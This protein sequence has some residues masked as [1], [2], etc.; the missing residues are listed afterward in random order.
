MIKLNKLITE[1]IS[2]VKILVSYD[3][4]NKLFKIKDKETSEIIKEGDE[5]SVEAFL[6][7][8]GARMDTP[9]FMANYPVTKVNSNAADMSHFSPFSLLE[10][11]RLRHDGT[12]LELVMYPREYQEGCKF[13]PGIKIP[14]GECLIKDIKESSMINLMV[15]QKE[16][17]KDIK[18]IA[19]RTYKEND[20][21]EIA[22][23]T[24]D[25]KYYPFVI[26]PKE[27]DSFANSLILIL[28]GNEISLN[29]EDLKK[30]CNQQDALTV[31]S[32][33]PK[34]C[35]SEDTITEGMAIDKLINSHVVVFESTDLN[36][37][38]RTMF[39]VHPEATY[40]NWK[41][42]EIKENADTNKFYF[43]VQGNNTDALL[44]DDFVLGRLLSENVYITHRTPLHESSPLDKA[45]FALRNG[46][47]LK[48][49]VDSLIK[50][51]LN[52]NKAEKTIKECG[53][54]DVGV[55]TATLAA[56]ALVT[57]STINCNCDN[58]GVTLADIMPAIGQKQFDVKKK[59]KVAKEPK[60]EVKVNDNITNANPNKTPFR[61]EVLEQMGLTE[62][63]SQLVKYLTEDEDDLPVDNAVAT[64]EP[65]A[66]EPSAT[67]GDDSNI[68]FDNLPT[69]PSMDT[70]SSLPSSDT[71]G[72]NAENVET[73]EEPKEVFKAS[74]SSE[75]PEEAI[76]KGLEGEEF[77]EPYDNLVVNGSQQKS[78]EEQ[79]M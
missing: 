37:L 4:Q 63:Y 29:P 61:E 23:V 51:Q 5:I 66:S 38:S 2:G 57:S 53:L 15:C 28:D 69:I 14:L 64:E 20:N 17:L 73:K 54:G 36:S 41:V 1:S 70:D 48:E 46:L 34:C 7:I 24:K 30:A 3:D 44:N 22:L 9:R 35:E 47:S 11:L 27:T 12:E 18:K 21:R 55:T 25:N 75:L 50:E 39:H 10:F 71:L 43:E 13:V 72:Q 49:A 52:Y 65:Q 8:N 32:Q 59:A 26:E 58:T 60:G 42:S 79:M 45:V 31:I 67:L 77:S 62:Q 56:P 16:S 33:D 78:S 19:V 6:N 74:D 76:L 40:R 68:S